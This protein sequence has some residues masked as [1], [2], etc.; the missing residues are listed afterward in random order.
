MHGRMP[1]LQ[2]KM[3]PF[4]LNES[5]LNQIAAL[6]QFRRRAKTDFFL[7]AFFSNGLRSCTVIPY[8]I[9]LRYMAF[10]QQKRQKAHA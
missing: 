10:L 6:R 4:S 2:A 9:V 5:R 8:V 7:Y 3:T 1:E